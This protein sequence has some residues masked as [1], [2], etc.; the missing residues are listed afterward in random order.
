MLCCLTNK[1]WRDCD[2]LSIIDTSLFNV[3]LSMNT[4][5]LSREH[6]RTLLNQ[7]VAKHHCFSYSN[8]ASPSYHHQEDSTCKN[9]LHLAAN[10]KGCK[11]S[12]K[13]EYIQHL[14]VHS[15]PVSLPLQVVDTPTYLQVS[16]S[17]PMM[18]IDQVVV[19][20]LLHSTTISLVTNLKS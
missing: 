10:I 19:L 11:F 5:K 1:S 4:L 12:Q 14:P 20:F 13:M 16:T 2:I 7:L 18:F 3:L 6:P 9:R 8:A 17:S 15:L